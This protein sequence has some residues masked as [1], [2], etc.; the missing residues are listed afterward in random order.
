LGPAIA[1]LGAAS[2]AGLLGE[3]VVSGR[4]DQIAPAGDGQFGVH[5][6]GVHGWPPRLVFLGSRLAGA[7]FGAIRG[8]HR[9]TT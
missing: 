7:G 5:K 2:Q 3:T 4:P 8:D 6:A 1:E 9:F